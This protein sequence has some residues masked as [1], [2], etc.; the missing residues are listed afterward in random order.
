MGQILVTI[1]VLIAVSVSG[2]E[3]ERIVTTYPN[4]QDVKEVYHVLKSDKKIKHGD[5]FLFFKGELS[6]KD[7]KKE[8]IYD[9]I[10]GIKER[11]H[12]SNNLKDG[13]WT[14]FQEP[15][16]SEK[17]ESGVYSFD[18]KIGVWEKHIENGKVIKRFDFDLNK[19]LDSIVKF[20][21]GY[22][23]QARRNLI[24]GTVTIKI[25]YVNCEPTDYEI[26]KDI[27]YGCG[28]SVIK[29]LKEFKALQKKYGVV[30]QNCDK[31]DET[32]DFK[33]VLNK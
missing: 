24:E 25:S 22:P 26:I 15:T 23:T 13:Q 20:T 33:F 30:L 1:L 14:Y 31:A 7:L 28:D 5:Y 17:L 18:K 4:S 9:M 3:T 6:K 2:Q 21:F 29:A 8:N 10:L 11:G 19:D 16:S 32:K 12:F 27:G